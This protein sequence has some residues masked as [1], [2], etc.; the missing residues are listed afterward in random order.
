MVL[1]RAAQTHVDLH[2]TDWVTTQ[3]ED[4][5][6]KTMIKWISNQKVQDLKAPA[7][8]MMQELRK[9]KLFSKSGKS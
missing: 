9:G 8:K 3:Q 7:G 5:I 6:L 2:V 1:A 4:P